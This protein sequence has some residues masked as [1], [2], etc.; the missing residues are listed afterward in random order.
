MPSLTASF[1]SFYIRWIRQSKVVYDSAENT[2]K[3]LHESYIRPQDFHPPTNLGSD[4]IIDRVDLNDWPLYQISATVPSLESEPR[5]ALLY[6]H[7]GAF[8]REITPQHWN[9]TAQ[10]ARETSLDV[11][12][13]IYPLL[14]RPGATAQKLATGLVEICRASKQTIVSICGDSAGGMLALSSTQQLRDTEPELFAKV[15]SLILI[16]PVLD[17]GL[18]HPEVVRLSEVDPWLGIDGLRSITPILAADLPLKHPIASPLYGSIENLPPTLLLSG[19]YDMLCADARRLKSKFTGKDIDQA[20]AGSIE[21][22]RFVY[23]EKEE[24]IHVW[25]L[26][27]HPEGAEGRKLIFHFIKKYSER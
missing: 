15:D 10:I 11:L 18:D 24:M 12:V 26:L 5:K 21:M 16:S 17:V 3:L 22:D 14:P 20:L 1:V 4:I 7:G 9:L 13:P 8:I 27:P 6:I 25:P 23:L 19:T 2:L